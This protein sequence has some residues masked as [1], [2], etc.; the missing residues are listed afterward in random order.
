MEQTIRFFLLGE[1]ITY[2]LAALIHAGF[3]IGGYFHRQANIA[4]SVIAFVLI[5]GLLLTLI[6][7]AYTRAVGI[8]AQGFALALT[9]VG[10]TMIAIG[11]GPRTAPDIVYHAA[12][13]VVLIVG[14]VRAVRFR[15]Y[16]QLHA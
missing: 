3:L 13:I 16:E 1:G 11:I 14:L 5:A 9:L 15:A 6:R 8:G 7:P 10:V 4:E 12:I 2:V